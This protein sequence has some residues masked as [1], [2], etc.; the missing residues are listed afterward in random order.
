MSTL[1]P[2]PALE[3][4][5]EDEARSI[6]LEWGRLH[7][8]QV[9]LSGFLPVIATDGFYMRF[10]DKQWVG[11]ADFEAH[12]IAKRR[13]F[14]EIHDYTS[15]HVAVQEPFSMARTVMLWTYRHRPENSPTS[16]LLKVR[17]E[18]TW[19]FRRCP[20]SGCAFMQGHVVDRFEYIDGFRPV[21]AEQAAQVEDPHLD[22]RWTT[23]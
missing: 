21:S 6:I 4:V 22:P 2:V 23:R 3:P 17:I 14:D 7:D 10:G 11:Y 12:Q 9:G 16:Q 20:T 19:E 18:H 5:S 13:F 8:L 1:F 15:I